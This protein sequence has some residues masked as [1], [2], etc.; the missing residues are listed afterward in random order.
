MRIWPN[1]F[2]IGAEKSGTTSLYNYLDKI[3]EIFM[4][5]VKEP[6]YFSS[7][8][9]SLDLNPRRIKDEKT[10]LNLF[11]NVK[12]ETV[13]G[14]ASAVYWRD[15]EAP[16]LIHEKIP[17]AKIIIS[18]R[19]PV[20][21][22]YSGYLMGVRDGNIT[23][24]FHETIKKRISMRFT[25]KSPKTNNEINFLYYENIKRYLDIFG[26]NNVLVLIFEEWIKEPKSAM[27]EIL[28][29]LG[30]EYSLDDF[31]AE[32]HNPLRE[33][34][35]RG[36]LAKYFLVKGSKMKIT[37]NIMPQSIKYFISKNI[38]SKNQPKPK[39][40]EEVRQLLAKFLYN[41]VKKLQKLLGRQLPWP[42]FQY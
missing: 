14:E 31:K 18:L 7:V 38:L 12:N 23:K 26:K 15:P 35:P 33:N 2:I 25:L 24:S 6:W 41:D 3:P 1:L 30:L 9:S 20:E 4:S 21:R 34:I 36:K 8:V 29:F 27:Q 5:P 40:S 28:K 19:D 13:I 10:Y 16:K 37:N 32:I 42:N 22:F 17:H 39:M 11:K